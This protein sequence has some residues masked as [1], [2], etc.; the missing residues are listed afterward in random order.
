MYLLKYEDNDFMWKRTI[1]IKIIERTILR[2]LLGTTNID[3][4]KS[5]NDVYRKM[6]ILSNVSPKSLFIYLYFLIC[7]KNAILH[8][9]QTEA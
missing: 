4:D 1:S 8:V 7:V 6:C 2:E 5:D 9:E 3:S